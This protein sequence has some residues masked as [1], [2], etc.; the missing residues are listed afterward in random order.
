MKISTEIGS[1]ASRVGY[2]KAIEYCAEAG[3]D[4]FDFSMLD[5]ARYDWTTRQ[6]KAPTSPLSGPDYKAYVQS[7][8]QVADRC[9]IPCNQSHAPFPSCPEIRD[10]LE[11]SLECTAIMGGSICIIHP[12]DYGS[13]EKNAQLYRKLLPA[14]KKYGVKIAVENMWN[15]SAEQ[16]FLPAACSAPQD[17]LAHLQAIDDPDVVA[18]LDIGHAELEGLGTSAVEMIYQLKDHLQALHI[19]DVDRHHDSHQIPF[20]LNIDFEAVVR[21]LKDVGYSGYFTLEAYTYLRAY[22]TENLFAGVQEMAKQARRLA[23]MFEQL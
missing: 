12:D 18:C 14:A 1:I 23:D 15:G 2:E 6:M 4:A 21:A 11:R 20:S 9:G 7:L 3:F 19:H 10:F 16:G 13:A 5:M 8:R 17:F 22:E